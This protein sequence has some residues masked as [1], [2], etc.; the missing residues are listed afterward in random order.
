MEAWDLRSS[1]RYSGSERQRPKE[2]D[3]HYTEFLGGCAPLNEEKSYTLTFVR[4]CVCL[5][6][7]CRCDRG[8]GVPELGPLPSPSKVDKKDITGQSVRSTRLA[9]Q[10]KKVNAPEQ[11]VS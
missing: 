8:G 4:R 1:T 9:D 11:R 2:K 3:R 5:V 6:C 10:E 7:L